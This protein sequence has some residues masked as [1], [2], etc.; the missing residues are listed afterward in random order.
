MISITQICAYVG[1]GVHGESVGRLRAK[2]SP[3]VP[4]WLV[5]YCIS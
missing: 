1:Q 4:L 2:D 5:Y 3:Y